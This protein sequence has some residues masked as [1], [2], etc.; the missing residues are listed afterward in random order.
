LSGQVLT[1]CGGSPFNNNKLGRKGIGLGKRAP[2][3]TELERLAKVARDT[4]DTNKESFRDRSRRE[5]EQ[6]RA[7]AR[8]GPAQRTCVTLDERAGKEVNIETASCIYPSLVHTRFTPFP[9]HLSNEKKKW[10]SA[11]GLVPQ[12]NALWLDPINPD[13]FPVGLLDALAASTA[14]AAAASTAATPAWSGKGEERSIEERLREQMHA[15]ALQPLDDDDDAD[16]DDDVPKN[17]DFDSESHLPPKWIEDAAQFL[18]L[19]VSI[20]YL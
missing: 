20:T 11:N 5:Y 10:L 3:P 6:R 13:T 4:E 12:F 14:A 9:S 18:H 1:L 16:D 7:E 15:D 2:S 17:A 8:L 19:N